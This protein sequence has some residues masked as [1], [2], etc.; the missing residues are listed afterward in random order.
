MQP[1]GWYGATVASI[2]GSANSGHTHEH[3][4]LCRS[5]PATR[6]EMHALG[7]SELQ[8]PRVVVPSSN[9]SPQAKAV[10]PPSVSGDANAVGLHPSSAVKVMLRSTM[11]A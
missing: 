5:V 11:S 9:F 1:E 6:W 7:A 10:R 2:D 3:K 8:I 4:T